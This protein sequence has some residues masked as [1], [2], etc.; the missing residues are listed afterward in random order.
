MG[1][2]LR[3]QRLEDEIVETDE[4]GQQDG[5]EDKG[6]EAQARRQRGRGLWSVRQEF[7]YQRAI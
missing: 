3:H 6:S 2:S 5:R 7:D 4:S 1:N